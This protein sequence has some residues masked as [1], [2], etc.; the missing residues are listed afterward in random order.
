[1]PPVNSILIRKNVFEVNFQFHQDRLQ[2]V[3]GQMML[4]MFNAVKS[5]IGYAGF[6]GEL[7]VRKL[8]AFFSQELR[9]LPVQIALHP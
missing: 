4:A 7:G 8:S 1:M 2:F 6:F 9:Q 3:Q 5:L